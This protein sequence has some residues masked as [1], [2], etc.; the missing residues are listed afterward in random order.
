MGT[1]KIIV[2]THKPGFV[3]D[4]DLFMPLQVGKAVAGTNLGFQGDDTGDN[5]SLKNPNYCELTGMY[6]A[7]KNLRDV[8]YVG[9]AHYRRYFRFQGMEKWKNVEDGQTILVNP[10][11]ELSGYD[12][13]LPSPWRMEQ[14]VA[15]AY[16]YAHVMEDFYIMNRVILRHYPDYEKT[17]VDFFFR[18]NKWIGYNMFFSSW[19]WFDSYCRWLFPIL[20]EIE[21][22]VRIST[23][24]IK[25]RVFGF[26]GELLLPLY[27]LHNGFKIKYLPL[28]FVGGKN[29]VGMMNNIRLDALS[30]RNTL[31]FLMMR[32]K[33]KNISSRGLLCHIDT[34]FKQD[35]III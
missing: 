20:A 18:S 22:H 7:W 3:L 33:H 34:Y 13:I 12:V 24:S 16:V 23:Y 25:K 29:I 10:V 4:N 26:M 1:A 11:K 31:K 27:C 5:I 8:D 35:G 19:S 30:V 14:S 6:W 9:L 17:M 32:P 28:V 15:D 2:C 21:S